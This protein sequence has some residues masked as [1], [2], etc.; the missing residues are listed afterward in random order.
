MRFAVDITRT[1]LPLRYR[2]R[3]GFRN[4]KIRLENS[5][6]VNYE[7]WW[8]LG[9]DITLEWC[10]VLNKEATMWSYRKSKA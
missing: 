10:G 3:V 2:R 4:S 8:L 1:K 5:G 7:R 9:Y 6:F